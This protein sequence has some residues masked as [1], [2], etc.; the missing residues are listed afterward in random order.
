MFEQSFFCILFGNYAF[1]TFG[2]SF[3]S[4]NLCKCCPEMAYFVKNC[5]LLFYDGIKF[6]KLIN[7]VKYSQKSFTL[8]I[9]AK[10]AIL[11]QFFKDFFEQQ[12][13]RSHKWSYRPGWI[14][15]V[16]QLILLHCAYWSLEIRWK[17]LEYWYF[18]FKVIFRL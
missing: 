7:F 14:D 1:N 17:N 15:D 8:T 10:L 6:K 2:F 9:I 4:I 13:S 12:L 5:G 16:I 3:S 11:H 18:I